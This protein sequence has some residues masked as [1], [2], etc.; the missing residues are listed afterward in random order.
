MRIPVWS[1]WPVS[2]WILFRTNRVENASPAASGLN[3]CS[4]F[5]NGLPG[6]KERKG[7]WS[8]LLNWEIQSKNR[9][10]ADWDRLPPIRYLA[11]LNTSATNMYEHIRHKYCRS[12]VCSDLFISPCQNACPAG[13]NVPGYISL[14]A[15]GRVRDAYN[16]IRQ[17]N[18]VPRR[19]VAVSAPIPAKANVAG[20]NWTNQSPSL[21]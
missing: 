15:A 17:E 1:I 7:M 9:P 4:K 12:G 10:S 21:T 2:L 14:I 16:L 11:P 5:L 19:S 8:Y 18:P 3:G 13:V 6:A 20:P